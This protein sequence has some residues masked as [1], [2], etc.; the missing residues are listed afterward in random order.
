MMV[1]ILFLLGFMLS[2]LGLW[3]QSETLITEE[4]E[5]IMTPIL[6]GT[7]VLEWNDVTIYM[8]PYG[9][10]D[11]FASFADA[12]LMCITH[13]H[14]DHLNKETL[15]GLELS[16]TTLMAPRSV[17]DELGDIG[18]KEVMVLANG[19][20]KSFAGVEV[21]AVPM[22][23]LPD[24]ASSRHPKGWGNGYVLSIGNKR[25]YFSGDTEDIPEMRQLEAIDFAFVCMNLPY[26]MD[27]DAAAD[28]VLDF[29]PAVVYP[30]HYRGQNGLSDVEAFRQLVTTKNQSIEVR[31][32]NWYPE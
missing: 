5:V 19:D 1:R 23:N 11:R 8:D 7:L 25:F 12:D 10:A 24:D 6:H 16:N 3:S 13:A 14:G 31:L 22:Y 15:A 18:F 29:K 27:V 9:G 32:R 28:A 21:E 20:R 26:T 17:V 2:N 4:G 30:Y